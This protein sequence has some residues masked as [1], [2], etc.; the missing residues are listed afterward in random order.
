MRRGR[1][2][3][4]LLSQMRQLQ[5]HRMT[6]HVEEIQNLSYLI[7]LVCCQRFDSLWWESQYR[8]A[9]EWHKWVSWFKSPGES[10]VV[11]VVECLSPSNQEEGCVSL[12]G[13]CCR[14][15]SLFLNYTTD[16]SLSLL[17][18]A[19]GSLNLLLLLPPLWTIIA[20]WTRV[21]KRTTS[22]VYFQRK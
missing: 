12:G 14:K 6:W 3:L 9:D 2:C 1:P 22:R 7:F 4:S 11:L 18:S 10:D 16:V 17:L 19:L 15:T 5:W 8:S 21:W 20:H 13:S